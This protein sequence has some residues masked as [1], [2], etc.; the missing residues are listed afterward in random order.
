MQLGVN[1]IVATVQAVAGLFNPATA[2]ETVSNSA[3]IVGIVAMSGGFFSQGLAE[4]LF[5]MALISVS[6]GIMNL[7]PI[8]RSTAAASSSRCFRNSRVKWSR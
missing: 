8:P 4:S 1:Y 5:F 6:L 3:S 2:A 7:L